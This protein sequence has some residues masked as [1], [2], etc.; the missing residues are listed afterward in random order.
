MTERRRRRR[1]RESNLV[2]GVGVGFALALLSVVTA[3]MT[4]HRM[5]D[6][7]QQAVLSIDPLAGVGQEPTTPGAPAANRLSRAGLG[8]GGEIILDGI[9][10]PAGDLRLDHAPA[11][12]AGGVLD[13]VAPGEHEVSVWRDGL[14]VW[15]QSVTVEEAG[16]ARLVLPDSV[17]T[18]GPAPPTHHRRKPAAIAPADSNAV[19]AP[20]TPAVDGSPVDHD[21]L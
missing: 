3:D 5:P 2:V 1:R 8:L 13:H 9:G 6:A 10:L 16:S 17:T 7:V 14:P 20:S 19:P 15:R 18:P 4:G 21:T 12:A 11:Q